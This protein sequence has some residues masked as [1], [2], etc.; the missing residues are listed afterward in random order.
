MTSPFV[1]PEW[2]DDRGPYKNGTETW[3]STRR[4]DTVSTAAR[5]S[6]ITVSVPKKCIPKIHF[7]ADSLHL[8]RIN[9]KSFY[10]LFSSLPTPFFVDPLEDEK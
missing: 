4:P 6:D 3:E 2:T 10:C 1:Y 9:K 8:S 5:A 7:S